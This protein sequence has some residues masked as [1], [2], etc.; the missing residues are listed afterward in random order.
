MGYVLWAILIVLRQTDPV[1]LRHPKGICPDGKSACHSLGR[2]CM[3][4]CMNDDGDCTGVSSRAIGAL[5][6]D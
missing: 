5:R 2:R 1:G 3:L 6:D 4:G